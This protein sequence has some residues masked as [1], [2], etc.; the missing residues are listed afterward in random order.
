MVVQFGVAG[1]ALLRERWVWAAPGSPHVGCTSTDR[2][3]R[4][5]GYIP[6]QA[7]KRPKMDAPL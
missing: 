1:E 5:R 4:R 7:A 2:Q 3:G 6:H